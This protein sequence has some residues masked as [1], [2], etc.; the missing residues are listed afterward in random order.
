M[1]YAT[2][3][4]LK[5]YLGITDATDD[6]AITL[7]LS[8]ASALIDRY[9]KFGTPVSPV[10]D[11]IKQACLIQA[12][13]IFSRKSSPYGIAGSPETG[14]LRLLNSLDVDVQQLLAGFRTIIIE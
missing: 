12:S 5:T 7:S 4:D 3:A 9:C 14:E 8:A 11:A 13:R 1:A 10:P 6:A 2:D